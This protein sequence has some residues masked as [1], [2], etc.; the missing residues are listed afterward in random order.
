MRSSPFKYA[1]LI[2]ITFLLIGENCMAQNFD[3]FEGKSSQ[4][5]LDLS[6]YFTTPNE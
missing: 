5:Q 3:P 2:L 1:A 6:R 4:Y